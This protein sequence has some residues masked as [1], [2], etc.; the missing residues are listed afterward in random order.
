[1]QTGQ[2][3]PISSMMVENIH[4]LAEVV[5]DTKAAAAEAELT[6]HIEAVSSVSISSLA[7]G[8]QA[9]PDTMLLLMAEEN[10]LLLPQCEEN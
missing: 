7:H 5:N 1:M 8:P 3:P 9:E 4:Y 10:A 2:I 6:Q